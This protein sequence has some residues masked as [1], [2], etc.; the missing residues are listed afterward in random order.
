MDNCLHSIAI[1]IVGPSTSGQTN[2]TDTS[3]SRDVPQQLRRQTYVGGMPA[4]AVRLHSVLSLAFCLS[5]FWEAFL[6][7]ARLIGFSLAI[8]TLPLPTPCLGEAEV[9]TI[10]L[11]KIFKFKK[12]VSCFEMFLRSGNFCPVRDTVSSPPPYPTCRHGGGGANQ[13][14]T[15]LALFR[16]L[17]F[18]FAN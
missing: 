5:G 6:P 10:F 15:V 7:L 1:L 11:K 14:P 16:F 12:N 4:T 3:N 9:L 18:F 8:D 17:R 13:E 2:I